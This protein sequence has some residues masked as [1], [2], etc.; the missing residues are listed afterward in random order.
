MSRKLNNELSEYLTSK[1]WTPSNAREIVENMIDGGFVEA[2][3]I[4]ETNPERLAK[5]ARAWIGTTPGISFGYASGWS[6]EGW[7]HVLN[8]KFDA[9]DIQIRKDIFAALVILAKEDGIEL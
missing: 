9:H 2:D 6:E 3:P 4:P 5:T 7:E 1:G 8:E